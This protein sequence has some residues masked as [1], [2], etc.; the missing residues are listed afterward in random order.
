M[1]AQAV[2]MM[3]ASMSASAVWLFAVPHSKLAQPWNV[4]GGNLISSMT[5]VSCAR[6]ITDMLLAAAMSTACII[7][8]LAIAIAFN[9]LFDY[10]RYPARHT[11]AGIQAISHDENYP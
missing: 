4:M 3:V 11:N 1:Y 8:I 9:T 7:V 6:L 10:Y 2:V 5:G